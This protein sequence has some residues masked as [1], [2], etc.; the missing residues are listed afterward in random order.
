MMLRYGWDLGEVAMPRAAKELA[1]LAR[2][3]EAMDRHGLDAIVARAGLNCTYLAGF[4]Y[5]GTLARHVDLADSPRAVI[6]IWPRHG[7]PRMVFECG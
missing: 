5:P 2:L 7:E 6:L 3:E 1:N 4:A